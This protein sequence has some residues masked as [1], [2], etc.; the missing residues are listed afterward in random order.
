MKKIL[1]P[2]DFSD[3]SR[4]AI[5]FAQVLFEEIR[6]EFYLLHVYSNAPHPG[7]TFLQE[8]IEPSVVR[9]LHQ[10]LAQITCQPV[11]DYHA[12]Y[13]LA[14]PSDPVNL[15]KAIIEHDGYDYIVVG[16]SGAGGSSQLGHVAV[17]LIRQ[18]K[19]NVLVVPPSVSLNPIREIVLATDYSTLNQVSCLR[20]LEE[21]VVRNKAHLTGLSIVDDQLALLN[22]EAYKIDRQRLDRVF[23]SIET[24]PYLILDKTVEGRIN[25]Y[26]D[27]HSINLLVTVPD[28][29]LLQTQKWDNSLTY[30]LAF[31]PRVPLL[32]LYDPEPVEP[33][34]S[35]NGNKIKEPV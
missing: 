20:P 2:T 3:A 6:V 24:G 34:K 30:Q 12:Y 5:H 32:A 21:F 18:A 28:R 13:I 33:T 22:G 19:T 4:K 8:D 1:L 35:G 15:V 29:K 26:L 31:K 17:G 16:S 7:Y 14:L 27:T 11:P 25:T 9:H 10:F 23:D